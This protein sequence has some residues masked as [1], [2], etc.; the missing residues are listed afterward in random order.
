MT[1]VPINAKTT[2][3]V[4]KEIIDILTIGG[5]EFSIPHG[6][7]AL[8]PS[9]AEL[10]DIS[11]KDKVLTVNFSKD[12]LDYDQ[13]Y[14]EEL[15]E[16]LVYS[17]TALKE[18]DYVILKVEGK[19]LTELPKTKRNLPAMLSRDIG[20]NKEYHIVNTKDI[21]KYTVYYVGKSNGNSYYVPVTKYIN[22]KEKNK[23]KVKIII[24]ELISGPSINSRLLSLIHPSTNLE[25]Y[26]LE[27]G[28][29]T[30]N[31]NKYILA[32]INTSEILEEVLYSI[33]YSLTENE[34]LKSVIFYVGDEKIKEIN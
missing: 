5:Q 14:E 16:S 32:D 20:I 29:A 15:I 34:D 21:D 2:I 33:A 25:N 10:K 13:N 28:K 3:D 27:D 31:F 7:R 17:L 4:A 26:T 8:I 24:E 11:Y 19:V 9:F 12:F 22:N 23:D 30:L 1:K 18:V 6:F